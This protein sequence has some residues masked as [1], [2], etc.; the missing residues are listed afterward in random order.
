MQKYRIAIVAIVALFLGVIE[1]K[2]LPV[3]WALDI[4]CSAGLGFGDGDQSLQGQYTIVE[5][6][7]PNPPEDYAGLVLAGER[8]VSPDNAE[9]IMSEIDIIS[10]CDTIT[11]VSFWANI[12]RNPPA[13]WSEVWLYDANNTEVGHGQYIHDTNI[14]SNQWYQDTYNFSDSDN[15]ARVRILVAISHTAEKQWEELYYTYLDS[16]AIFGTNTVSENASPLAEGDISTTFGPKSSPMTPAY[17]FDALGN[18]PGFDENNTL[19]VVANSD[20]AFVHAVADGV[21]TSVSDSTDCESF[22]GCYLSMRGTDNGDPVYLIQDIRAFDATVITIEDNTWIYTY[23]VDNVEMEFSVYP[24]DEISEGCV[25]GRTLALEAVP[26]VTDAFVDLPALPQAEAANLNVDSLRNDDYGYGLA[27][28][29][30]EGKAS[31]LGIN[32]L[33]FTRYPDTTFACGAGSLTCINFNPEFNNDAAGWEGNFQAGSGVPVVVPGNGDIF[34]N[35]ELDESFS[36]TVVIFAQ[37]YE[38]SAYIGYDSASGYLFL[39]SYQSALIDVD[40]SPVFVADFSG[41]TLAE[42]PLH[43]LE[44]RASYESAEIGITRIC[45]SSSA[46][47]PPTGCYFKDP[48]FDMAETGNSWSF[49]AWGMSTGYGYWMVDSNGGVTQTAHLFAADGGGAAE[50]ELLVDVIGVSPGEDGYDPS[51]GAPAIV[52]VYYK[53]PSTGTWFLVGDVQLADPRPVSTTFTVG[54]ETNDTFGVMFVV[55]DSTG[56]SHPAGS[57]YAHVSTICMDGEWYGYDVDPASTNPDCATI[58]PEET[59]SI[60]AQIRW[61]WS[62][63]NQFFQCEL[64]PSVHNIEN[65]TNSIYTSIQRQMRYGRAYSWYGSGWLRLQFFPWLEGWFQNFQPSIITGSYDVIG[66]DLGG[67]CG[68]WCQI[69]KGLNSIVGLGQSLF[70][71]AGWVISFL[72]KLIGVS[73]FIIDLIRRIGDLVLSAINEAI[74]GGRWI[75]EVFASLI[76]SWNTTPPTTVINLHCTASPNSNLIC[77]SVWVLDNTAFAADSPALILIYLLIGIGSLFLVI[78]VIEDVRNA[79]L[80][81]GKVA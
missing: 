3:A 27:V 56:A 52:S 38:Q 59:D 61:Q 53:Y 42:L 55:R 21:V 11:Q 4:P 65:T 28:V 6:Y 48:Y 44:F 50:Y 39:D 17:A 1:W 70:D 41:Y 10:P 36:Y 31:G 62:K 75:W 45:V 20:T 8:H 80:E 66:D 23:L 43:K 13:Y 37:R 67:D 57:A 26:Y 35:I 34:Q 63:F 5:G 54:A 76:A 58:S 49:S 79:L 25:L 69:G 18:I 47:A 16:I 74:G 7:I 68:F 9:N 64:M 40:S 15:V 71:A 46:G 51:V 12:A 29:Y 77:Q 78:W 2:A 22:G 81:S 73:G 24:G 60:K 32:Q 30:K 14:N 33:P 72:D 19:Y